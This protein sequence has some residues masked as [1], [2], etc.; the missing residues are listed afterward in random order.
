MNLEEEIDEEDQR[1]QG[2]HCNIGETGRRD[3]QEIEIEAHEDRVESGEMEGQEELGGMET[4][5]MEADKEKEQTEEVRKK[6][7][8]AKKQAGKCQYRIED[9][10]Q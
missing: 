5:E 7:I 9:S 10:E 3:M 4:E 8:E 1:G 2:E 6:E